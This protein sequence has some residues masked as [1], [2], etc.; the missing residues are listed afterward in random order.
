MWYHLNKFFLA[1][2]EIAKER[3]LNSYYEQELKFVI[4]EILFNKNRYYH[5]LFEAIISLHILKIETDFSLHVFYRY[6]W[7]PVAMNG[8]SRLLLDSPLFDPILGIR[9]ICHLGS[10]KNYVTLDSGIFTCCNPWVYNK[11]CIM[12]I[13]KSFVLCNFWIT[14]KVFAELMIM[15]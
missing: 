10:F 4:K 12:L 2:V 9:W 11:S 7:S 15:C 13:F 5:S 3:R 14:S 8:V 6:I 1:I